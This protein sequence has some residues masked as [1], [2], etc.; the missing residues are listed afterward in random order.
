M[1]LA[2]DSPRGIAA[3]AAKFALHDDIR[4]TDPRFGDKLR[5]STFAVMRVAL[6]R[7]RI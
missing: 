4:V 2:R 5:E 7:P 6:A 3:F 1:T